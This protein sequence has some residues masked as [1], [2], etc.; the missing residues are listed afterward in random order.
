MTKAIASDVCSCCLTT[1]CLHLNYASRSHH[2]ST[3][4]KITPSAK[5]KESLPKALIHAICKLGWSQK[6]QPNSLGTWRLRISHLKPIRALSA[7]IQKSHHSRSAYPLRYVLVRIR[8]RKCIF[9]TP[10]PR[11]GIMINIINIRLVVQ[12]QVHVFFTFIVTC[13]IP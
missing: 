13:V 9:R 8:I 11:W 1:T 10:A 3:P 2:A 6:G 7:V 5:K 12:A 4:T